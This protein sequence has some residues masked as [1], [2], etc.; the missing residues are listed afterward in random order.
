[1]TAVGLDVSEQMI[2][3]A[4]KRWPDSDFRFGDARDLPLGDATAAGYRADKV[5]HDLDD[6]AKALV[7]A[8]RVLRPS[9]RIVLIGQDWD[10]F[11]IDSGDPALTRTI[12][13]ARADAV[14]SPRSTRGY[15]TLLLDAGFTRCHRPGADGDVHR[16]DH[17]PACSPASRTRPCPS[18]P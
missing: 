10:T 16:R 3:A 2:A 12:V 13:H 4:R 7:E 18:A 11:V 8:R 6:P 15:R 9:G 1:M 17:A 5:F 14:P